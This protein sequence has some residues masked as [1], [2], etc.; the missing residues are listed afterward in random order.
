MNISGK[1][2]ACTFRVEGRFYPE[3][4]GS[5][6]LQITQ[7]HNPEDRKPIF[8]AMRTSNLKLVTEVTL[9]KVTLLIKNVDAFTSFLGTE[10]QQY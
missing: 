4:G 3:D 2:T 1:H 7:C 8:T 9:Y 6:F 5:M 10:I